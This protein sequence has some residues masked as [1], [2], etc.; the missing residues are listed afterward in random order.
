MLRVGG[1][2][3]TKR[4]LVEGFGEGFR[5]GHLLHLEGV[6]SGAH[7]EQELIAK[8]IARRPDFAFEAIPLA[9]PAGLGVSAAIAKNRELERNQRE[10]R[11]ERLQLFFGS[12][13]WPGSRPESAL[14]PLMS[15]SEAERSQSADTIVGTSDGTGSSPST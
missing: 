12:V 10:M 4:E 13:I 8:H 11:K 15:R 1:G 14:R 3:V 9:E 2:L 7:H 5:V 6:E